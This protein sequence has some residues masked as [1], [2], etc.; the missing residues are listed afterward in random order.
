MR[1]FA[2]KLVC[3]RTYAL[4]ENQN[5]RP[6]HLVLRNTLTRKSEGSFE[7]KLQVELSS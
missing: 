1:L 3:F 4:T 6:L 7:Q 2:L 5:V